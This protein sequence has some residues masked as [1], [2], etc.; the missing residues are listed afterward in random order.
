M[1]RFGS[2]PGHFHGAK[3]AVYLNRDGTLKWP[4]QLTGDARWDYEEWMASVDGDGRSRVGDRMFAARMNARRH[5]T[6]KSLVQ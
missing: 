1:R 5:S 3:P 2:K 4:D 6:C